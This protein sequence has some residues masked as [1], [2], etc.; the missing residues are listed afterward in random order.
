M[1][2]EPV[3]DLSAVHQPGTFDIVIRQSGYLTC[4]SSV[5]AWQLKCG[6]Q[7]AMAT[8]LCSLVHLRMYT[9]MKVPGTRHNFGSTLNTIEYCHL[10]ELGS[11]SL[12]ITLGPIQL[13][14]FACSK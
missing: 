14:T 8:D 5:H 9:W 1:T 12:G 13:L 6:G 3:A 4:C 10:L 2:A 7:A 11:C